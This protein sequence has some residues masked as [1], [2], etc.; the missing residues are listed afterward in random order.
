MNGGALHT[1]LHRK[2]FGSLVSV[3]LGTRHVCS[4]EHSLPFTLASKQT[5]IGNVLQQDTVCL[6]CF[7]GHLVG[8]CKIQE[9]GLDVSLA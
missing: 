5:W 8:Y 9:A 4:Q 1:F 2:D 7:Q 3:G 6:V